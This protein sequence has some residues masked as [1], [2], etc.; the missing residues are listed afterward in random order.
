MLLLLLLVDWIFD[1]EVLV[2]G[3]PDVKFEVTDDVDDIPV[4]GLYDCF[5]ML[6]IF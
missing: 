2:D 6:L 5:L 3:V 4:L 1:D